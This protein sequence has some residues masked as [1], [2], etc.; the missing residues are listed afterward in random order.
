[1]QLDE[2]LKQQLIDL[3]KQGKEVPASYKN[4]LF[5]PE[6]EPKEI[7]LKYGIK[8]REEDI[9]ADT[10]AMPYQPIKKFGNIKESEWHNKLIFGD[11]LQA[12]KYLKKLQDEEKLEKIK[13][14]Y[15]DPPF[16]TGDIYDAKG[17]PAYSAA[18]QGATYLEFLRKR[19]IFLRELLANDGS[20][21]V[22]IDYHYGHYVKV[23]MDEVFGKNN[24][25]NELIV[26]RT[27]K[28]FEGINRFNTATDSVFFYTVTGNYVFNG[29]KKERLQQK[30][31]AMH[32]PGIR[33]TMVDQEYLRFYEKNQL[34]EKNK[35]FCSRGRVFNNVV[36]MPPDGRHWTFTQERLNQYLDEG[37]IRLNPNT[38]M[39]EYLTSP[40]ERT[41]SNWTDIPGYSQMWNYPTENSEQLL[42]RIISASSKPGDLVLDCFA[43]AGT[44]GAVAEK[45][46]RK[47]IMVDS[48]KL[49]IYTITKR[50]HNLRKEIGN[51][52]EKLLPKPFILYNAGLYENHD[53]ILKMGEANFKQ[54]ALELF[55]ADPKEGFE[56]NGLELDGMLFN[57]P[58]KVFLQDGYLTEEYIE[59]LHATVGEYIKT[60]M[61]VIAPASRVY[62]LQDYIEKENKRYYILRIPYSIIDELHKKAF[63]RPMQPNS[64][65]EINQ[66]MEQVGF[67]FNY[68]PNVDADYYRRKP[69][70]KL[71]EDEL[72]IEIKKFEAAQISKNPLTLKD[73]KD[74][75]SMVLIDT[76]YN[77]T[78]FNMTHY[79]FADTIK[80]NDYN[81]RIPAE[82][83]GEKIGII[84]IDIFGNERIEVRSTKDFRRK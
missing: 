15:I 17:A 73:P 51:A 37:R 61:F 66:N 59:Q 77:N 62:F 78:Y 63:T 42:E 21:Y 54:F 82:D 44:T 45:L 26:N 5:S 52:G 12:L 38:S 11:N 29:F 33:W 41:D 19:L 14:I 8:E 47:W 84:Y 24:F 40:M 28:V 69:K 31:I 10:M 58:V 67:D 30:W 50:L 55:Q 23:L 22:R 1:M 13:L 4:L 76:K 7:E 75:L 27:K 68:Q 70:D 34:K 46:G 49:A 20:I 74:A 43:G 57:S 64:I 79:F 83:I 53:F 18:L 39:P 6:Q 80:T 9:L 35:G 32:S 56:I 25:K 65:K 71:I 72:V 60:R 2:E 16:G 3:I 36:I 48:S 81:I